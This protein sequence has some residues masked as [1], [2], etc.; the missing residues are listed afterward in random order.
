LNL[1]GYPAS[2][3]I[4]RQECIQGTPQHVETQVIGFLQVLQQHGFDSFSSLN[5]MVS[6]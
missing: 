1:P 5:S 3:F 4:T 2:G 6:C